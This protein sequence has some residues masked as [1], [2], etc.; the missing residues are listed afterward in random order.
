MHFQE[1]MERRDIVNY[2]YATMQCPRV[3]GSFRNSSQ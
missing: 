3:S 2:V 1:S